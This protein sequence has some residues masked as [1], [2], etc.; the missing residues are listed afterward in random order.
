MIAAV[1][2]TIPGLMYLR[3]P[4]ASRQ[5]SAGETL[6]KQAESVKEETKA[7]AQAVSTPEAKKEEGIQEPQTPNQESAS[8]TLESAS[9]TLE[10]AS[11]SGSEGA[12]TPSRSSSGST[13]MDDSRESQ[14]QKL[15]DKLPSQ[16]VDP[17]QK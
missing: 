4:G 1:A 6:V 3:K 14:A 7:V 13:E 10:S 16:R 8:S 11:S 17:T 2:V 9:S 12:P 5:G 15:T